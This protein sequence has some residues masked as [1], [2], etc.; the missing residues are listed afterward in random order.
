MK[1]IINCAAYASGQRLADVELFKVH[2]V[3][4]EPDKFVW[5]GLHEPSE[6]VL[7]LVQREFD[8][9]DLAIEDAHRA[10][11]RPKIELYGDS[12]FVVLRT[13]QINRESRI[14][15]GETH[16]FVGDNFI[17]SVRH[18]SSVPYT[19]V[20]ARCES[21]PELL[22]LGQGF[23][24]YAIMD[25]IVD[26]YFPVVNEL[27]LALVALEER[28]FNEKPT[29]HTTAHI[30][31]LKRELL[32]VKRAVSPLIDICNRLM[33]LE[34]SII[35]DESLPYF[36]DIYDHAVRINEMVDNTRELLNTALEANF[37]LISIS[38]NDTSKR[39]AGWA[40]I[41][42]VPTM[43]AGFYGMNFKFMPELE[44]QYGYYAVIILTVIACSLLY[45][46]F[47][48]SGWL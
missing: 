41:L 26:R 40:A 38:Q 28:I 15:F 2:D 25:F 20:R 39:F 5:I 30:Y 6:E 44:W 36:R 32:E 37:S 27:E 31:Q 17:V 21:K 23:V 10:H 14:E 22:S 34:S 1:E 29:R 3:L 16:F 33:R 43:I 45:Y 13:A 46:F 48:R 18:G 8:L 12:I 19:E 7:S 42:A 9:H 11:Q 24:L 35:R 47:R 4:S